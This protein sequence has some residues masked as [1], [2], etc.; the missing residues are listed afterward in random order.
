MRI[1]YDMNCCIEID[2]VTG[3]QVVIAGVCDDSMVPG[4]SG[5]QAPATSAGLPTPQGISVNA[6]GTKV[7]ICESQ[8]GSIRVVDRRTGIID[9]FHT[10]VDAGA[11]CNRIRFFAP[12]TGNPYLL[13]TYFNPGGVE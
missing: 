9:T 7:Y 10:A 8:S 3:Q 6:D 12:A 13:A 11:G 1:Q 5:D 2:H 4:A